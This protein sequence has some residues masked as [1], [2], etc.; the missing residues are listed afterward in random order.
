MNKIQEWAARLL[1]PGQI[2]AL[3]QYDVPI[4]G[5][6]G[7]RSYLAE[8]NIEA[9]AELYFPEKF[10]EPLAE[11]HKQFIIDINDVV[12]RLKNKKPG[13]KKAYAI[14][15]AHSKTTWFAQL[16][17]LYALLY[18]Y[19]PLTVL[20]AANQTA[21]DRLLR[22][23]E[24]LFNESPALKEDFGT[25]RWGI[26]RIEYEGNIVL[27]FGMGSGAIRGV[28]AKTRPTLIIGDD[29]D[30]DA[31]VRS[32]VELSSNKEWLDKVVLQLG[33]NVSFTTSF[34][35]IGTII[36][37]TSL[38]RYML[39][40]PMFQRSIERAVVQFADNQALWQQWKEHI[41][42]LARE[43]KQPADP[44]EDTFYQEHKDAL[45]VGT[46]MLWDRKDA[47]Y[48]AMLY[49]LRSEA[50]FWSELMN[51]PKD[52][53]RSLDQVRYI[54]IPDDAEYELLAA[55]DPTTTGS[56]TSDLAAYIEI[57]FHRKR[58][59]IIVSYVDAQRRSYSQTIE[60]VIRRVKQHKEQG[61]RYDGFWIETNSSGLIIRDLLQER[62]QN[63]GLIVR[64]VGINNRIPKAERIA[65]MSEYISRGQL[66]FANNLP[67]EVIHELELWPVSQTD[68]CLDAL[69]TVVL[70][71]RD[72]GL[73]DLIKV[74]NDMRIIGESF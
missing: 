31:A 43:N 39:D 38:L 5:H 50:A 58:K 19:S 52:I 10:T 33:D 70:Q 34:L 7:L 11:I 2:E 26:E 14:P 9:F 64:V 67:P 66:L 46:K 60:D 69:S 56:K 68:D 24:T 22:N 36:R 74:D 20:L 72:L 35:M 32:T 73:L 51:E 62:M 53:T 63:E 71:L 25:P 30:T 8:Q 49:R 40:S 55:I 16:L 18:G 13:I 57:L 37:K 59:E 54:P 3:L 21:A 28:N 47:Y 48:Y 17:P 41:L 27:G 1:T 6:D 45:L 12:D 23:I 65:A 29:L 42:A 4:A 44:S 15:R 61:R